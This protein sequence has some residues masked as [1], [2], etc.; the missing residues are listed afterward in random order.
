MQS[1]SQN[2]N[3]RFLYTLFIFF[4]QRILFLISFFLVLLCALLWTKRKERSIGDDITS[5]YPPKPESNDKLKAERKFS[6][7]PCNMSE[8]AIDCSITRIFCISFS[9]NSYPRSFDLGL[10]INRHAFLSQDCYFGFHYNNTNNALSKTLFLGA[11]LNRAFL[12]VAP[13]GE[14][15]IHRRDLTFNLLNVVE[16]SRQSFVWRRE[17]SLRS[18]EG[19]LPSFPARVHLN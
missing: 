4:V 13:R 16:V 7:N 9:S 1:I 2:Y 6:K 12:T 10:K 3:F 5:F 8:I 19:L 17:H 11:D 18:G 15:K 14:D